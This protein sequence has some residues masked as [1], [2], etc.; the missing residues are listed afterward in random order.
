MRT[1]RVLAV[2]DHKMTMLGYKFILEGTVFNG[3]NVTL[4][5]ENSFATGKAKILAASKAKEDYDILLLDIQLI[6]EKGEIPYTGEDLGIFARKISPESKIVFMSSFSDNF[7]INSILKTVNP[8]GYMVKT[9]I[10]EDTLKD[11][12][13]VVL[14]T[15]P[16]YSTK[17][18][19]A[20]RNK[21]SNDIFLDDTDKKILYYL[22]IGYKTK[23]MVP[24]VSLSIS[25]IENRKR[26]LKDVFGV[27]KE[28]DHALLH[29]A[30]EKGFI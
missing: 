21:I 11:M 20:I 23:D 30:K 6:A 4:D 3:F 12:V 2:D 28:N 14:T 27:G 29:T 18:L 22:S 26:H 9:E 17:A 8:E 10:N 16:Y 1:I 13:E 19:V 25:A 24:H 7:R 15:P 5:I